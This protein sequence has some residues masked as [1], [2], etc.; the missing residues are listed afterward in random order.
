M[1]VQTCGQNGV[2]LADGA[3][4]NQYQLQIVARKTGLG[5]GDIFGDRIILAI[6]FSGRK[7]DK[8][9][10]P[11]IGLAVLGKVADIADGH[12]DRAIGFIQLIAAG[13]RLSPR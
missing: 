9:C 11:A 3:I 6:A 1:A 13:I 5:E 4:A 7:G 10:T 12:I 2:V 8:W